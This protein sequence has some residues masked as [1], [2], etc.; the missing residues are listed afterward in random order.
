MCSVEMSHL[1]DGKSALHAF[2]HES[3]ATFAGAH[4]AARLKEDRSLLVR[5]DHAFLDLGP[6]ERRKERKID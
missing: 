1:L 6:V 2:L 5:T 3:G 4:V